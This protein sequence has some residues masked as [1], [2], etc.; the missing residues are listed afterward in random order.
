MIC[1]SEET[2]TPTPEQITAAARALSDHNA[3]VCNVNREDNWMIYGESF[4]ESAEIALRAAL[5]TTEAPMRPTDDALDAIWPEPG[6]TET[7][8]FDDAIAP[9]EGAWIAVPKD[10]FVPGQMARAFKA[11]DAGE[12]DP[13][14]VA[15]PNGNLMKLGFHADDEVDRAHAEFIADA[16][17]AAL[18]AS[19]AFALRSL[20]TL[21]DSAKE[22]T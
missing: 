8:I 4:C 3:H 22:G 6:D 7:A 21:A 15:L 5:A 11:P 17:N 13:W 12:H 1:H 20:Y 9:T 14:Y 10:F 2:M 16:I 18:A 19:P